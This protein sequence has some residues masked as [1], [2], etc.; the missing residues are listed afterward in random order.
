MEVDMKSEKTLCQSFRRNPDGSWTSIY[1]TRLDT[2]L[3]T[4]QLNA[5]TRFQP[6]DYFMGIDL[7]ARLEAECGEV[8]KG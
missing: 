8:T 6:G 3:V 7:V 1:Q 2:P 5:G 4:I